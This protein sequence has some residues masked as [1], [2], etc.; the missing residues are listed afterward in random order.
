MSR[1]A[2]PT[3]KKKDFVKS[4]KQICIYSFPRKALFKFSLQNT[5]LNLEKIE[6]IEIL[7]FLELGYEIDML[8][9]D[10]KSFSIDTKKDLR[11][12]QRL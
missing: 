4:W 6:D 11:K 12:A 8:K 5:K 2:I 1:A 10:G 3:T 7:R 9:L